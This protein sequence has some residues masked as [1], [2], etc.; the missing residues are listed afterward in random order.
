M[1]ESYHWPGNFR[2]LENT[3]ESA[4]AFCRS[5]E[6]AAS[7]LQLPFQAIHDA[8]VPE[9]NGTFIGMT[10]AELERQAIVDTLIA[11]HGNKA[12][13]ARSLGISLRSVYNKMDRHGIV[14]NR[15][16]AQ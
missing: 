12:K 3:L 16:S 2:E 15:L 7:D 11:N 6:V 13:T 10:L 5:S 9:P 8:A 4:I 14:L 1:L